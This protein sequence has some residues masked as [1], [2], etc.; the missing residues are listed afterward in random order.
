MCERFLAGNEGHFASFNLRDA[1]ANLCNL[2][3]RDVWWNGAGEAL[4]KAVSKFGALLRRKLFRFF[5]DLC[6]G[7]SHGFRVQGNGCP[8]KVEKLPM[9]TQE[10]GVA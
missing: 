1:T 8:V 2:C 9:L 7:L 6:D 10:A 5:K 3:L 4:H